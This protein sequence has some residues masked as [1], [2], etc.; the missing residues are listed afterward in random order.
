MRT[1]AKTAASRVG[2][3][4]HFR[5]KLP[6]E[7]GG[8]WFPASIEGGTKFL[9]RDLRKADPSLVRFAA[10]YVHPQEK[11]WDVGANVGF[12]TFMAAGLGAYVLAVEADIWLAQNI[13][14]AAAKQDLAVDVLPAAVSDVSGVSEFNIAMRNRAANYLTDAGGSTVTG[15]IRER[16][17]VP[18]VS[19]DALLDRNG[20]PDVVKIDIEGGELAALRGARRVL[21]GQPTMLV[22][23]F[24]RNSKD[25][26]ELLRGYGYR[27]IDADSG[28]PVDSPPYNTIA[29]ADR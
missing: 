21:H 9:R 25:V 28:F 16:Q 5:R 23:V 13:R 10:T 6:T 29:V 14:L 27:F 11:V 22:E 7:L 18:T 12:F 17:L 19:L 20:P 4:R 24:Q 15:G 3:D 2:R 26:N 1:I 8:A